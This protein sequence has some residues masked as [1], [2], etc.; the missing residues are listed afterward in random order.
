[1][2]HSM[3]HSS[4]KKNNI[5]MKFMKD[6]NIV[7]RIVL[8]NSGKKCRDNYNVNIDFMSSIDRCVRYIDRASC[9]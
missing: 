6:K 1:M 9:R 4:L 5:H 8:E 7:Q 2:N 3:N